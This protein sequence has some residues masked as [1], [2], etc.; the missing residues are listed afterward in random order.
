MRFNKRGQELSVNTLILIIIGVLI[1]VF[2]IIGF[3]IGWKKIFPFLTPGNNIKDLVDKCSLACNTNARYDFCT[4]K[5]DVRVDEPLPA[6][7]QSEIWKKK[8]KK[9]KTEFKA[10]CHDLSLLKDD[11]G[12]E[13]C[14]SFECNGYSPDFQEI[15]RT[16]KPT[17][18]EEQIIGRTSRSTGLPS[19]APAPAR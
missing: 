1:L 14:P 4:A 12:L 8:T 16:L 5:R 13:E 10:T 7:E 3:T 11:I 18:T 19:P 17:L 6:L 2:L 15:A 9:D